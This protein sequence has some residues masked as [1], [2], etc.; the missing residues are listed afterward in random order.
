MKTIIVTAESYKKFVA[1]I[2]EVLLGRLEYPKWSSTYPELWLRKDEGPYVIKAANFWHT[3]QEL[4]KDGIPIFLMQSK[5]NG[6]TV[7]HTPKEPHRV[8]TL[9]PKTTWS[10]N[11]AL[12]SHKG[13]ELLTIASD[14]SWKKFTTRYIITCSDEFGSDEQEQLLLL[15]SLHFFKVI[16]S[17]AAVGA[18]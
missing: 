8:F 16:E 2:D 7:I 13:E 14:F 9:K 10:M 11:Y 6:H 5:W 18:S 12:F 1:T 4:L 15:L 17:A 3:K